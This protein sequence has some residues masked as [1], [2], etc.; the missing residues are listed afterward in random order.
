VENS[1][2]ADN[3]N[4]DINKNNKS[5]KWF[6]IKKHKNIISNIIIF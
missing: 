3:D 6:D 2:K 1:D 5:N 4:F